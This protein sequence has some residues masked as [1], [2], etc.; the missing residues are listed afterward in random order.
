MSRSALISH[1]LTCR[2]VHRP[3]HLRRFVSPPRK[4]TVSG[5]TDFRCRSQ[6]VTCKHNVITGGVMVRPNGVHPCHTQSNRPRVGGWDTERAAWQRTRAST[7]HVSQQRQTN[8]GSAMRARSPGNA[9]E[10][11]PITS[12]TSH[13]LR[14]GH[15]TG[16]HL[17]QVQQA[18]RQQRAS[19]L[20]SHASSAPGPVVVCGPAHVTICAHLPCAHVPDCAPAVPPETVCFASAK[21]NSLR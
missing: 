4:Q 11:A 8:V 14:S 12:P 17:K 6:T 21:T 13:N 3:S 18:Q 20:T 10:R 9:H 15:I 5:K 2:T 19:H 16:T 1:A 7:D